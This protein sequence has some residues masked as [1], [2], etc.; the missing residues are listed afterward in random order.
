MRYVEAITDRAQTDIDSLTAKAF[1]NVID[2][3]RIYNNSQVAKAIVDFLLSINVSFDELTE[4][5]ITTIPA[6]TEIN[7]LLANIEAIRAASGLPEIDGITE[8]FS[9]WQEGPGANAP[10]Y[11]DVNEWERILEALIRSFPAMID[12]QIRCGVSATGQIRFYQYRFRRLT[13]VPDDPSFVRRSRTGIANSGVGLTRN[14]S[15][16]RYA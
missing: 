5:S 13:F 16:R 4:P 3:Q 6:V 15:F 1:F 11:L 10:D 2:W 7:T 8:I 9:D 14:N 12:Y